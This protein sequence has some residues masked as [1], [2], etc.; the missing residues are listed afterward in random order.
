MDDSGGGRQTADER[1][2]SYGAQQAAG[3]TDKQ[4]QDPAS[5]R[6][7]SRRTRRAAER[8]S[9]LEPGTGGTTDTVGGE[10]NQAYSKAGSKQVSPE[11]SK[12]SQ[13][14]YPKHLT[15]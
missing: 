4:L 9:G 5:S 6:K 8:A 14:L 15:G 1:A 13:Q 12:A 10:E 11:S 3:E 7:S 2:S